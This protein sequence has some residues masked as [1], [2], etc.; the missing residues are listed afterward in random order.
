[1]GS[2]LNMEK[3]E[4]LSV[5]DNSD[6]LQFELWVDGHLAK[7]D[8]KEAK[9]KIYLIHTEVAPEL[10]GQGVASVL[11]RKTLE[12]LKDR[13]RPIMPFCPY[14]KAYIIRHPEWKEIVHSSFKF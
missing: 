8:Y 2:W 9:G 12:L 13:G 10:K 5:Q 6:D 1:M 7:I 14:V 11:V 4:T 3:F